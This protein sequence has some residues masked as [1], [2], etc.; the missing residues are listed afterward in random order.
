MTQ[1]ITWPGIRCGRDLWASDS[2][3]RMECLSRCLCELL[4][5]QWPG[6]GIITRMAVSGWES[7]E[8][9]IMAFSDKVRSQLSHH[10]MCIP[11][12]RACEGH[13]DDES[14]R[15]YYP[16][17]IIPIIEEKECYQAAFQSGQ[18]RALCNIATG[19]QP[20]SV[21]VRKSKFGV[22]FKL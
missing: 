18:A 11:V 20:T 4:S 7:W 17:V 21:T 10:L 14:L 16:G 15:N 8:Q 12:S 2:E 13:D 5:D 1:M 19:H 3:L 22:C 9:S 6:P